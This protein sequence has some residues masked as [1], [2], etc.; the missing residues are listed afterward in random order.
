MQMGRLRHKKVSAPAQVTQLAEPRLPNFI[1]GSRTPEDT[2]ALEP[3]TQLNSWQGV[4]TF[5]NKCGFRSLHTCCSRIGI[6]V[7]G[8]RL[9]SRP[10][11]L[12]YTAAAGLL[13]VWCDRTKGRAG[14]VTPAL[15]GEQPGPPAH[16]LTAQS[17]LPEAGRCRIYPWEGCEAPLNYLLL[18]GAEPPASCLHYL[19][20]SCTVV[21]M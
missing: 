12:K 17:S 11:S 13:H 5:A 15:C 14:C 2:P 1:A 10:C 9:A 20:P 8:Q 16:P 6:G 3:L 4:T 18:K 21:Y 7:W 19:A